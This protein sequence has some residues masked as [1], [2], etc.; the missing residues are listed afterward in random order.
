MKRVASDEADLRL[1]AWQYSSEE[2]SQRWRAVAD[3]VFHLT[4]LKVS[5]NQNAQEIWLN[6]TSAV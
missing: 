2:T 6:E 1:S 3:T 4:G 5:T